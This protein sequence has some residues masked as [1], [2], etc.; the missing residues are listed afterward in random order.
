MQIGD[1]G[2]AAKCTMI[3]AA[4]DVVIGMSSLCPP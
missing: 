2:L 3:E 4:V 1:I